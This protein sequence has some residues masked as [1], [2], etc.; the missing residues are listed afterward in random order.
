MLLKFLK[1]I[2]STWVIITFFLLVI[3]MMI[4]YVFIYFLPKHKKIDAV[5]R[6]NR[7]F[8]FVWSIFSFFTYKVTGLN[9]YNTNQS[10][11]VVLNHNNAAD[12]FAAAYGL[13]I[14]A[15]PLI[16]KELLRIPL[17]GQLFMMA[18]TPVDRSSAEGRKQSKELIYSELAQGVSPLIFP[19]GTRNRT[20]FPLKDFYN[21]A[22]EIAIDTQTPILP[23]VLTN[24]RKLNKVDTWLAEPGVI[25]INHLQPI[26]TKG[27]TIDDLDKLK[28]YT[29]AIMWNY[30][31]KHDDDFKHNELKSIST[32]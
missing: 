23:V 8:L 10:Y 17:L 29:H 15:K 25:E 9:L 28:L 14:P 27:M 12:M 13:R 20:T 11:V 18:C 32:I 30:L 31:V 19:E 2:Y 22:F 5:Y 7:T 24:I 6:I 4:A 21:G 26:E 16:K 1:L 3:P